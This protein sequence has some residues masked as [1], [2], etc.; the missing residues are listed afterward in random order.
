VVDPEDSV[1]FDWY[2]TGD[3]QLSISTSSRIEGIGFSGPVTFGKTYDLLR[4]GVSQMFK[5]PD[6]ASVAAMHFVSELAGFEVGPSTG[7]NF[8][9]ALRLMGQMSREG[10]GGSIVSIICDEGSRYRD[11]YYRPEWLKEVGLNPEP[12]LPVLKRFWNTG[13]L[14]EPSPVPV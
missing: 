2:L 5:V 8:Y 1:L 12:W 9:G 3:E 11:H 4:E 10:R 6:S 13:E 7:T 14:R